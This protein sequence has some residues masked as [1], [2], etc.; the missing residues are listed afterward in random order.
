MSHA[1]DRESAFEF[2]ADPCAVQAS[3]STHSGHSLLNR[4][5]DEAGRA[6]F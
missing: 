6:V 3:N 2:G 1:L 5:D 4:L